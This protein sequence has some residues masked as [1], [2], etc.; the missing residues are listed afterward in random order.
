MLS[1]IIVM[2][3][4]YSRLEKTIE[5]LKSQIDVNF[6]DW[7]ILLYDGSDRSEF[8]KIETNSN[9]N[10]RHIFGK[11]HGI[12]DAMNKAAMHVTKPY[13]HFLNCGDE[14]ASL[15]TISKTIDFLK[16][17]TFYLGLWDYFNAETQ[18]KVR[19][20]D[21]SLKTLLTGKS[22]YCHQAQI[23]SASIF[24]RHKYNTN[25]QLCADYLL[26]L[27]LLSISKPIPLGFLGI[28]YEGSGFSSQKIQ[29]IRFEKK[30]AIK[31]W[32]NQ[33]NT[34]EKLKNIRSIIFA[35][36]WNSSIFLTAVLRRL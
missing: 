15:D 31:L 22:S 16:K 4:D 20:T 33:M 28:V 25:L 3:N 34:T 8:V 23:M 13:I 1:T 35:L 30:L 27:Q 24:E 9:L 5:S 7:E 12:Y 19:M 6:D 11:D 18:M 26:T 17:N 21:L 2:K 10:F 29:Q 32:I 36:T 14:V